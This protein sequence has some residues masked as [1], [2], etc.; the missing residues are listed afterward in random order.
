LRG[1]KVDEAEG[2]A[3]ALEVEDAVEDEEAGPES[4]G[5]CRNERLER[6]DPQN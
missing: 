4:D 2:D 3:G 5:S 1:R 6:S